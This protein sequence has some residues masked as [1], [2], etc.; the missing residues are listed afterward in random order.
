MDCLGIVIWN[1]GSGL[2]PANLHSAL[3]VLD[4]LHDWDVMFLQEHLHGGHSVYTVQGHQVL[5]G[6]SKGQNVAASIVVNSRLARHVRFDKMSAWR[7]GIAV[8]VHMGSLH[9]VLESRHLPHRDLSP[10]AYESSVNQCIAH[11]ESVACT[12]SQVMLGLES[13]SSP[14]YQECLRFGD[15][16]RFGHFSR[17]C[18][19]LGVS[20]CTTNR[21][22]TYIGW[23]TT[24]WRTTAR[25]YDH[26]LVPD[27]MSADL[28]PV[29]HLEAI[30]DSDHRPVFGQVNTGWGQI[31]TWRVPKRCRLAVWTGT[32]QIS[33]LHREQ[34][35]ER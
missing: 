19:A 7:E 26:V 22:P 10:G 35:E 27:D 18:N 11:L 1:T 21:F 31:R 34:G 23:P 14:D 29:T 15:A 32:H 9:L 6:C 28:Y 33:G 4:L 20:A 8:A 30:K 12:G 25:A 24:R 2:G 16:G 13:N 3:N 5:T 17:L